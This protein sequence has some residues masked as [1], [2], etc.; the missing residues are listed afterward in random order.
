VSHLSVVMTTQQ[1]DEMMSQTTTG[2]TDVTSSWSSVAELFYDYLLLVTAVIGTAA[3]GLVIYALVASEQHKKHELI[4]NQNAIDLYTCLVLVIIYGLKC[5]NIYYT[6]SFGYWLCMLLFNQSLLFCGF[7]ASWINLVFVTIE[8]YLIVVHHVWS[9]KHLHKWMT[10]VTIAIPWIC[11]FINEMAFTLA[12]KTSAVVDGI[13]YGFVIMSPSASFAYFIYNFFFTYVFVIAIVILCYAKILLVIRR[14]AR[15]MASHSA[16][17][18]G[19]NAAQAKKNKMQVNVIKTMILVC[20]FYAITWLPE[21]IFAI[22][23]GHKLNKNIMVISHYVALYMA[24]FY[25][26]TNP[27]IYAIKFDPV[28]RILKGLLMCKEVAA[29]DSVQVT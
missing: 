12:F 14:Q 10:Y 6:G 8:R 28:R 27:F 4:V 26:C 22:L 5:F 19:L 1:G 29:D 15:V 21:K 2:E 24:C 20:A 16:D 11:G 23:I 17:D 9:K 25:I 7:Y 13:C 3:N 18:G